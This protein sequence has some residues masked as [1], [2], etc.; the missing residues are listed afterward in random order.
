MQKQIPTERNGWHSESGVRTEDI[1]K[2]NTERMKIATH[3]KLRWQKT[4]PW[5]VV[6]K[7]KQFIDDFELL[8]YSETNLFF[9]LI[10]M[11]WLKTKRP[12]H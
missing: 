6:E 4:L 12:K 3:K 2:R 7:I 5:L 9:I 11:F 8:C 1:V 10:Y